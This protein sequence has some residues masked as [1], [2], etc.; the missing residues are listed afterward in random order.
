MTV[1]IETLS[2]IMRICK[3]LFHADGSVTQ[4]EIQV[5]YNFLKTFG[6]MNEQLM[7]EIMEGA[8][9]MT[10]DRALELIDEVDEAAKQQ[11]SDLFAEI[12]CADGEIDE[13]EHKLYYTVKTACHLPDP[14]ASESDAEEEPAPAD[15]D[16]D[17]MPA[18]MVIRF[19]GVTYFQ[20]SN[21]EGHAL[22]D[23]LAGWIGGKRVEV[24]RFTNPLN[25]LTEK[26]NLNQ[27]HV[28]FMIARGATGTTG[29]NM[30]AT[31]LYGGGYPLYGDIIVALETDGDY[32][33]EGFATRSLLH[34]ALDAVN[35]AVDGLL[36]SRS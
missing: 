6:E 18:F 15:P 17:I 7:T 28:I 3:Y 9:A 4:D 5:A 26:L 12:V 10:D 30:P 11:L 27:R 16:D 20:Q 14:T 2:A 34:E 29:D 36:R 22:E 31:L 8:D 23:E 35:E 21:E 25:K 24:V 13:M 32:E 33:I 1:T 19:D